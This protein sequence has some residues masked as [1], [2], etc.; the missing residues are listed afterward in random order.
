M[1]AWADRL[2][3]ERPAEARIS[4]SSE[5]ALGVTFPIRL[6]PRCLVCHGPKDYLMQEVREA[7]AEDYPDDRATGFAVGGLRGWFWVEVPGPTD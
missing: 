7:L 1:P 2:L 6:K 3:R 5:G 4:V